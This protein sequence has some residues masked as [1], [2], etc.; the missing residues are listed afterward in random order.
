MSIKRAKQRTSASGRETTDDDSYFAKPKEPEK[1]WEQH[2]EGRGDGDFPAYAMSSR[3]AKGML[4]S[5]AKF[6]RGVVVG[7]EA[8][9]VMILFQEGPKKLGHGVAG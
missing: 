2:M 3:Y 9:N 1:N 7:V 4:L 6:G 8:T 5:H